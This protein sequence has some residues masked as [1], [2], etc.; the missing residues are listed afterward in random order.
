[1]SAVLRGCNCNI[2][3]LFPTRISFMV[4]DLTTTAR[5]ISPFIFCE[6]ITFVASPSAIDIDWSGAWFGYF[7]CF[8]FAVTS[9]HLLSVNLPY[10]FFFWVLFVAACDSRRRTGLC[11]EQTSGHRFYRSGLPVYNADSH[12][13]HPC[14]LPAAW[15]FCYRG[16]DSARGEIVSLLIDVFYFIACSFRTMVFLCRLSEGYTHN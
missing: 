1:M 4:S 5:T 12:L 16:F 8:T 10:S 3:R 14:V 13:L 6:N 15:V 9:A 7:N 2:S 11:Q